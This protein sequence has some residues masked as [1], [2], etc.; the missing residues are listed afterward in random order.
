MKLEEQVVSLELAKKL[1]EL[2]CDQKSLFY[3]N[4]FGAVISNLDEED[5]DN[6]EGWKGRDELWSAYTV[7]ELGEMLPWDMKGGS[8][9][10]RGRF[11]IEKSSIEPVWKATYV[12]DWGRLS[13]SNNDNNLADSMAKLLVYLK[14]E[15]Q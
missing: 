9:G 8:H 11:V 4:G 15:S 2:G 5:Q 1:R 6:I 13:L 14:E 7:A 12:S 10:G 3:W